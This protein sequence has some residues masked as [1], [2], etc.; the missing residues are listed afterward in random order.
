MK[1]IDSLQL[2]GLNSFLN[3]VDVGDALLMGELEE[4]SCKMAGSDKKI[5]RSLDKELE[6][7][8]NTHSGAMNIA[9]SNS[10]NNNN[11]SSS[12]SNG[13]NGTLS[14]SMNSP[15]PTSNISVSPFG[16]LSNSTSRK[17]MIY[18]IQLLNLSFPD[19]DFTDSK[20]EQFQREPNLNLVINSINATLAGYIKDYYAEFEA[21]L[22]STLESEISLQKCEIYLYRPE[23]GD[24]FTE[25]GVLFSFNYFFYNKSL[26]KIIFFKCR[27]ISKLQ[28]LNVDELEAK[29]PL[30]D[31]EE[32]DDYYREYYDGDTINNMEM[33]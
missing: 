1:Y 5:Y 23:N 33:S 22:W 8:S 26:K 32:I 17:T 24:P 3:S 21:K 15:S 18:L 11:N 16:P 19:Y 31:Q 14:V 25:N 2:I 27:Y 10:N 12:N 28:I 9:N 13:D 6:E 30:P 4:Y 29:D 7:L 20:P